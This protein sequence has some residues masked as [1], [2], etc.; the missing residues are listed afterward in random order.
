MLN[1]RS[2]YGP[3]RKL[4]PLHELRKYEWL[5]LTEAVRTTPPRKN[6]P[7]SA[8]LFSS[9]YHQSVI[10][11]GAERSEAESKDLHFA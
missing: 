9:I 4:L 2:N 10:L 3:Q 1:L 7:A 6:S 11:S 8:G 5:L